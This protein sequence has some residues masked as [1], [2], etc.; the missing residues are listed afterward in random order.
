MFAFGQLL[1]PPCLGVADRPAASVVADDTPVADRIETV[2]DVLHG[3]GVLGEHEYG[4]VA[5]RQR[6]V[7]E[8]VEP[9]HLGLVAAGD[10]PDLVGQLVE[11][12]DLVVERPRLDGRADLGQ[13]VLEDHIIVR[14][15]SSAPSWPS[16]T[17]IRL[18]SDRSIAKNEE[19]RRWR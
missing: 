19:V 16:R 5:A 4:P 10:V 1:P 9:L 14:E 17:A 15:Q 18:R 11:M 13:G 6:V 8:G 2:P 12:G 3:V 7:D